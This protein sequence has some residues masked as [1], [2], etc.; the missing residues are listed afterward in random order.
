MNSLGTV[1]RPVNFPYWDV[2]FKGKPQHEP[3]DPFRIRHPSMDPGKRAKIFAPFDALT[4][5][6]EEVASKNILYEA[7]REATPEEEREL[8][9][10]LTILRGL[11]RHSRLAGDNRVQVSVTYYEPRA[12]GDGMT[13][14]YHT[15]TGI[16]RRIDEETEH[17]MLVDRIRIPLGSIL[18]IEAGELFDRDWEP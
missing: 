1:P 4:G 10:R 13:G 2:F 9:R 3:C 15:V 8:N 17:V 6:R 14:R 18:Q 16:C 5:F 11:T 7:L 12:G